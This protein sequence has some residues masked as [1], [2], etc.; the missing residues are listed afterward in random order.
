VLLA[1]IPASLHSQPFV[2]FETHG[3]SR[4]PATSTINTSFVDT[5]LPC[6]APIAISNMDWFTALLCSI[7]LALSG[8]ALVTGEDYRR[9]DRALLV[10]LT[11]VV[12]LEAMG[13]KQQHY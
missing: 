13:T 9:R 10:T 5:P 3:T 11:V 12:G 2:G 6:L 8:L 4:Q 1:G 7:F